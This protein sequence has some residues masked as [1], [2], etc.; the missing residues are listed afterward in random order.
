MAPVIKSSGYRARTVDWGLI[1][2]NEEVAH[3][4][5]SHTVQLCTGRLSSVLVPSLICGSSTHDFLPII[6]IELPQ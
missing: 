6:L 4:A 1:L 3:D 2:D 5:P